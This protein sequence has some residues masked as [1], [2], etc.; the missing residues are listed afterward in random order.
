MYNPWPIDK[1]NTV[2]KRKARLKPS[3]ERLLHPW[4]HWTQ[5]PNLEASKNCLEQAARPWRAIYRAKMTPEPQSIKEGEGQSDMIK[6]IHETSPS[7]APNQETLE[8]TTTL[9]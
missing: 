5:A 9:A 7:K 2:K 3:H 4:H 8:R 1:Q 6:L